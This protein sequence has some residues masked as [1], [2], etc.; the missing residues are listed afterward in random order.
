[1]VVTGSMVPLAN[2][3]ND[4]KVLLLASAAD[5][6]KHAQ[7]HPM[8]MTQIAYVQRNIVV[9]AMVAAELDI[10]EVCLFMVRPTILHCS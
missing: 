10:P 2:V 4:A 7:T 8:H 1:M 3:H 9:S 6:T 5:F